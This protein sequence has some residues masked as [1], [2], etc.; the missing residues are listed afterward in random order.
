MAIVKEPISPEVLDAL[1][2]DLQKAIEK[3]SAKHD[4][5]LELGKFR[6]IGK[7]YRSKAHT[8]IWVHKRQASARTSE[9]DPVRLKHIKEGLSMFG[10]KTNIAGKEVSVDAKAYR[11][12]EFNK[13]ATKYPF[14]AVKVS[15][16]KKVGLSVQQLLDAGYGN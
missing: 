3:L 7:L 1:N 11:I 10:L 4:V 16:G 9:I 14:L 12:Y 6:V 13:R 15:S 8:T 5:D 2:K